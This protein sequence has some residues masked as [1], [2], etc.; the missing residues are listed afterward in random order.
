MV[1]RPFSDKHIRNIHLLYNNKSNLP[2]KEFSLVLSFK[3]KIFCTAGNNQG[4]V[5]F[6][7]ILIPTFIRDFV[8]EYYIYL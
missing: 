1:P 8:C 2:K 3:T 4:L 6:F 5:Y 7:P